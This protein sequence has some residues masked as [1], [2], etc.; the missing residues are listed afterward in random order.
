MQ[1][2]L[3]RNVFDGYWIEDASGQRC[4]QPM[5]GRYFWGRLRFVFEGDRFSG[6]WGYCNAE[7]S[8][9]WTGTRAR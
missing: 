4:Q 3:N 7:P 9:S 5:N 2:V 8:S 1:G 6:Q